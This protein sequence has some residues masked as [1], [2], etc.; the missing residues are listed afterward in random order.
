MLQSLHIRNFAIIE[1]VT[2]ELGPG[3][4][5][6]SGETGAGKSIIIQALGLVTGQRGNADWIR[7]GKDEA[8]V[9]ALF[10]LSDRP[11]ILKHLEEAGVPLDGSEL[12]IQRTLSRTGRNQVRVNGMPSTVALLSELTAGLVDI[13]SQN[14]SHSLLSAEVQR[15]LLDEFGKLLPQREAYAKMFHAVQELTVQRDQIVATDKAHREQEEFLR[16]QCQ[17]IEA[18]KLQHGEDDE[19]RAEKGRVKNATKLGELCSFADEVLG[20]ASDAVLA[21]LSKLEGRLAQL[22][23]DDATLAKLIPVLQST[24]IELEDVGRTLSDYLGDLNFEPGRL[25]QIE[26]RLAELDRLKRKYGGSIE[27]VIEKGETLKTQLAALESHD[28]ALLTLEKKLTEAQQALMKVEATLQKERNKSAKRLQRE[29]KKELGDLG[30]GVAVFDV[31]WEA[32]SAGS[33]QIEDRFF[34]GSGASRAVFYLTANPGEDA[35]PLA[36]VASGGERSRILLAL[37]KVLLDCADLATSVFDEVDEGVGGGTSSKV[38]DKLAEVA[39]QRQVICITHQPQIAA[40]A[41]Q[42][43]VIEKHVTEGRTRTTVRLLET[44]ERE[45][46]IAR[47]L[48][49]REVTERARAHA[50]DL[51]QEDAR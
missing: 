36:K 30:L 14:E 40:S 25:E 16:F 24:L 37:K 9:T 50:R 15:D 46:E 48:S 44:H 13:V 19:L 32:L 10:Q 43:F 2:L 20:G 18:A 17:E 31:I 33:I 21:R 5:V 39:A 47:M 34:D 11:T 45:Q 6:L 22:A 35:L 3:F 7:K 26:Q 4:N 28:E 29:M 12:L 51:I 27:E 49:G 41:Q 8:I 1:D 23:E 42:H 38:G